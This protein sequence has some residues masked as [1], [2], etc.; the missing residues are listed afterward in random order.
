MA[1]GLGST[2]HNSMKDEIWLSRQISAACWAKPSTGIWGTGLSIRYFQVSIIR[3][4]NS[5]ATWDRVLS[6][7]RH[8]TLQFNHHVVAF[9]FQRID[10][11]L[12]SGILRCLARLGVPLPAVPRA[13]HFIS[14][15][16][17]LPQ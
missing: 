5:F 6:R 12:G 2:N 7:G 8:K 1:A 17:T 4:E 3:R 11:N 13:N 15:D 10:R 14:F 16:H 9:H